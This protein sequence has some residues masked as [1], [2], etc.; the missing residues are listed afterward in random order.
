LT[1][2]PSCLDLQC[3][4]G[5][6]RGRGGVLL[7]AVAR[8]GLLVRGGVC[9]ERLV[10]RWGGGFRRL[11]FRL[12]AWSIVAPSVWPSIPPSV[13]SCV[14]ACLSA[15][16]S[17]LARG[18][19]AR[20]RGGCLFLRRHLTQRQTNWPFTV[21]H[22]FFCCPSV[23]VCL[24]P[25]SARR[26]PCRHVT[27][28]FARCRP[29]LL[30]RGCSVHL[31]LL[32]DRPQFA[33]GEPVYLLWVL[34][35][36]SLSTPMA[37]LDALLGSSSTLVHSSCDACEDRAC[38]GAQQGC[39]NRP[40]PRVA[41][42]WACMHVSVCLSVSRAS[43]RPSASSG[44]RCSR[45]TCVY[46]SVCL[47]VRLQGEQQAKRKFGQQVQPVDV[48]APGALPLQIPILARVKALEVGGASLCLSCPCAPRSP[49]QALSILPVHSSVSCPGSASS[50]RRR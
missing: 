34:S 30:L 13:L 15:C 7:A 32:G 50:G 38:Q 49:V 48:L 43:S 31:S 5:C 12:L 14:P 2:P 3:P 33:Q 35:V 8:L 25:A 47:S 22:A 36:W 11:S 9:L 19:G 4:L 46:L 1:R 24:S 27:F 39:V 29:T 6:Q 16:L 44:S 41:C 17:C 18:P 21:R 26:L 45:L 37:E 42:A 40:W 10:W 28:I 20:V 23:C